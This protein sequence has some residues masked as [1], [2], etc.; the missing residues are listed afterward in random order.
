[1]LRAASNV[2]CKI[3]DCLG[4]FTHSA[5]ASTQS[6]FTLPSASA[7]AP[8]ASSADSKIPVRYFI[9]SSFKNGAFGGDR[10]RGRLFQQR[11]VSIVKI[12]G[13]CLTPYSAHV[14]ALD[15][16]KHGQLFRPLPIAPLDFDG[17]NRH[18][19]RNGLILACEPVHADLPALSYASPFPVECPLTK[20]VWHQYQAV[21]PSL[22]FRGKAFF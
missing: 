6:F 2:P 18:Q 22:V 11:Y 20:Q 19:S 12:S 3:D 8:V 5:F 9:N 15:E 7:Q 16:L 1:M 13:R 17:L 10:R 4:F 14:A 21:E